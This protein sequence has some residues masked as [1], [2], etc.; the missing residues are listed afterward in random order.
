MST[1]RTGTDAP[2]IAEIEPEPEPETGS[3]T[4]KLYGH[5]N[6]QAAW[7]F[8]ALVAI[9][10]VF[11]IATSGVFFSVTNIRNIAVDAS[12][13]LVLSVGMTYVVI[14]AGM[15]SRA[16]GADADGEVAAAQARGPE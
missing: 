7:P 13:L 6:S 14:T 10:T 4:S 2:G 1:E 12:V 9:V 3:W 5:A 11:T 8:G 16:N 15:L